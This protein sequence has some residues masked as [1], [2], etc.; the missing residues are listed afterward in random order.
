MGRLGRGT[1]RGTKR[2][3]PVRERMR[4]RH[5]D[6]KIKEAE[7]AGDIQSMNPQG[8]DRGPGPVKQN[9]PHTQRRCQAPRHCSEPWAEGSELGLKAGVGASL[10]GEGRKKADGAWHPSHSHPS[11][12][13]YSTRGTAGPPYPPGPGATLSPLSFANTPSGRVRHS[14]GQGRGWHHSTETAGGGQGRE[15]GRGP[16]PAL[17]RAVQGCSAWQGAGTMGSEAPGGGAKT[18][19]GSNHSNKSYAD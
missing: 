17:G 9:S 16:R 19:R 18:K 10:P 2:Q 7:H 11:L 14:S 4:Q 13:C 8:E 12:T 5:P 1:G 3:Q 15:M 6:R